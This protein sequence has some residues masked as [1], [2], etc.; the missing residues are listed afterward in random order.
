MVKNKGRF[1]KMDKK[2]NIGG[3][4]N[5]AIY[6]IIGVVVLF[7]LY[8]NLMPTLMDAGDNLSSSGVPLGTIFAS[9]GIVPLIVMVG[10]LLVVIGFFL[11]KGKK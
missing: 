1:K 9:T 11:V 3:I 4:V 6:G 5:K 8:A 7:L 2:G 10:L